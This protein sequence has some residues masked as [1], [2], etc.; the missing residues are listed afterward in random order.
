MDA[1]NARAIE[2]VAMEAGKGVDSRRGTDV[3]VSPK[4]LVSPRMR[5][6]EDFTLALAVADVIDSLQL[7][8]PL[9]TIFEQHGGCA[10]VQPEQTVV[11]RVLDLHDVKLNGISQDSS[12]SLPRQVRS[13]IRYFVREF[14]KLSQPVFL[15]PMGIKAQML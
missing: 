14:L 9:K 11:D 3:N 10:F 4:S 12:R 1:E 13:N 8:L 7:R 2:P 6:S 15:W 5:L